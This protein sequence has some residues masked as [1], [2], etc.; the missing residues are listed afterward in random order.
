MKALEVKHFSKDFG[1]MKVV[2][3]V[4]LSMEIGERRAIIGP[5]GAGKTTLLNMI[6]GQ[7]P[8]DSGQI[9][10][11][12]KNITNFPDYGRVELGIARS[13]Q[14][15]RL[16]FNL[17][18]FENI[19]LSIQAIKPYR[20]KMFRPKNTY[21]DLLSEVEELL[22]KWGLREK[23]GLPVRE[24]SYGEQRKVEVVMGLASKPKLI[25]LDEPTSGL[26]LHEIDYIIKFI[27]Q[28]GKDVTLLIVEHDM[29]VVFSIA[30]IITVLH[31]GEVVAEGNPQEIKNNT[32]VRE[33]YL[34]I[35]K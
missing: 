17:T 12:G 5:N 11:F 14:I 25:L 6:G 1:G 22:N 9:F 20:F 32:K 10:L 27:L 7:L 29:N 21:S 35:K 26:S 8:C 34:G 3:N 19:M 18:V 31:Y 33:T 13:F 30:T 16:F 23:R 15:M 4:S 24:L 2:N 28:I